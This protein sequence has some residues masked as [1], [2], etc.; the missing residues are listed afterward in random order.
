MDSDPDVLKLK[1]NVLLQN[2]ILD[3][4]SKTLDILIDQ[5]KWTIKNYIDWKKWLEGN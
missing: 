5:K 1:K 4:I 2:Q 3:L